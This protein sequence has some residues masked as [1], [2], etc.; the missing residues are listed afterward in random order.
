MAPYN[1]SV[2]PARLTIGNELITRI[3]KSSGCQQE[4][5]KNNKGQ[6]QEQKIKS[7]KNA[8]CLGHRQNWFA[9]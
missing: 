4:Q 1:V 6:E 5:K 2:Y 9:K 7:Y 8:I 3:G